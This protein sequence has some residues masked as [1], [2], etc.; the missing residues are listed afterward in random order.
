VPQQQLFVL[1]SDFI[2]EQA[3]A[4]A[5][6]V[7]Q[8]HDDVVKQVEHAYQLAFGRSPSEAELK[9]AQSYLEAERKRTTN[10]PV[11]SS[12]VRRFSRAMN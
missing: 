10:F 4:F 9:V 11:G 2:I 12:I 6:Q 3:K 8:K 7:T 1:N 5:K